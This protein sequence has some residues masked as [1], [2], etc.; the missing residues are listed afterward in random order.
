MGSLPF[1]R[2]LLAPALYERTVQ[3]LGGLQERGMIGN[4]CAHNGSAAVFILSDAARPGADCLVER[5]HA[6]GVRPVVMVTGDNRHTGE[7][8]ARQLGLDQV[9]TEQLPED[10]VARVEGLRKQLAAEP[11]RGT[12]RAVGVIGD[13]V[14][15][16][17]A[18]A[19]A[20]VSIA[21]GSIGSDAALENADIVLLA[22][23]LST[24]PWSVGLARRVRR[25]ITI[26][27]AFALGAMAL[28]AAG[29]V[30]G[31]LSGWRMPLW[32][33]VIGHEG[34][35]LLVVAHS[36]LILTHRGVPTCPRTSERVAEVEVRIEGRPLE[37]VT[38]S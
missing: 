29:V 20:G 32:M 3:M 34:G 13:G 26:N 28:M 8:V 33:G 35:T 14:N 16:A 1:V 4:V 19:A 37:P 38:G 18:L 30:A 27:L 9:H 7:A 5:L 2:P 11:G 12:R 25:T 6:L 24:V 23:D 31:S 22:D 36:L 17:P 21:I 15:D 10:K